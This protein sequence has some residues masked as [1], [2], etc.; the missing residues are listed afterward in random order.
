MLFLFRSI[1]FNAD[2]VFRRPSN[3]LKKRIRFLGLKRELQSKLQ[4]NFTE[5][6][7]SK[8]DKTLVLNIAKL[9]DSLTK[10]PDVR[11]MRQF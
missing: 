6:Q 1:D 11:Q 4:D 9:I 10:E 5:L 7:C 3:R 2:G 8:I